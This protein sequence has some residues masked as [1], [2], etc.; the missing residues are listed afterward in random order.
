M[1][2]FGVSTLANTCHAKEVV[3]PTALGP[4]LQPLVDGEAIEEHKQ[5]HKD[6]VYELGLVAACAVEIDHRRRFHS[7]RPHLG[8]SGDQTFHRAGYRVDQS[9]GGERQRKLWCALNITGTRQ[10]QVLAVTSERITKA[11]PNGG[12][13]N[14]KRTSYVVLSLSRPVE[15]DHGHVQRNR[16]SRILGYQVSIVRPLLFSE[17]PD[18]LQVWCRLRACGVYPPTPRHSCAQYATPAGWV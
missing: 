2:Y 8:V 15:T 18:L 13:C 4:V 17:N 3:V 9:V 16:I 7:V 6:A 14:P 10:L 1:R 11:A 5:R 12:P